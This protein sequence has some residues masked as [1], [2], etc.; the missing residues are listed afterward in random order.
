MRDAAPDPRDAAERQRRLRQLLAGYQVSR[1]LL[2]ADE[3][4]LIGFLQQG[5]ATADA[6]PRRS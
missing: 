4:G 5:G 6:G 2:A 3:L 1:A